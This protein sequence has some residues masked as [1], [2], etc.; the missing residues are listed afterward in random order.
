[1]RAHVVTLCGYE[2]VPIVAYVNITIMD[3]WVGQYVELWGS[4]GTYVFD[5]N[6]ER[7]LPWGVTVCP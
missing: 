7:I 5:W 6:G 3:S 4:D 2:K 1:M